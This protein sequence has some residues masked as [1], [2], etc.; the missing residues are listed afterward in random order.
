MNVPST[1]PPQAAAPTIG[2]ITALPHETA[3]VLTILGKPP[4]VH[5]PGAGPG[6]IY[7]R[8]QVRSAHGGE[9]PV[10]VAQADMGTNSAAIRATLLLSHFPSIESII[11]C[12]IAGG[13]PNP[14]KGEEHVRLGDIVVSN[15]KGVV[16][17]D[18]V[19][20]T[21]KKKVQVAKEVRAAPR[22][23]S[24]ALL[25]AVR[26][27]EAD[28]ELG[29]F[30]WEKH[31]RGLARRKW[32]RPDDATDRLTDPADLSKTLPHPEDGNRRPGQPR[33]FLAAIASA[34]TLLKDALERD[35]LR[36]QFGTRAV[37][38]EGSGIADAT[39]NHRVGYLVVRGI[40]D[41]CD[42]AK[43][44]L[45]HNYAAMAAAAYVRALLESIPGAA[46]VT[47]RPAPVPEPFPT[48]SYRKA[49]LER[50]GNLNLESID[51]TGAYYTL[52]LWSVFV[53]QWVRECHQF[54]PQLLEIPKEHQRRLRQRGE[55]DSE[56]DQPAET[57]DDQRRAYFEQPTRPALEVTDD[58]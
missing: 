11:M 28:R 58:A 22:P 2:V 50:Y 33:V 23:P 35:A 45:W 24:A 31:L 34:N 32:R 20:R 55:W 51:A 40:C 30:P 16:Q 43:N 47:P 56:Q 41:Y 7:W 5:V 44:D 38:M 39:W 1:A 27:L 15:Q 29:S 25:D 14:A 21:R 13:I 4:K 6:R 57:V 52:K 42:A 12:G 19:K 10:I 18:F 17:Y 54:Y 36:E 53:P 49:L 37:E 48:E 8:A 3:A 46:P 9:H 26:I